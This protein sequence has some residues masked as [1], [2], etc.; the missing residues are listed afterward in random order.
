MKSGLTSEEAVIKLK[1]SKPPP[2]GIE[3]Y[4]YLQQIWKQEQMSS[5]KD[6]LRWYNNEDV[7]PILDAM[8]KMIAFYHDKDIDM[9]KLGCTL[10]NLANI[11]LHKSTDAKFYQFTESDKD[12]IK[13]FEK[14]LLVVHPSILHANQLLMKL[15][16]E[17]LQTCANLLLG[18]MPANYILT[19][20]VNPCRP[21]SIRVGISI[22]KLV[23]S[24]LDKTRPAVLEIWSCLISN[25]QYQKVKLRAALQ[26]ADKKMTPSVLMG[27]VLNATLCS[28]PWVAFTT[29]ASAKSCVPLSLKRI[30]NVVASKKREL[31]AMRRHYI[32]EKGCKVIEM[33]EC[34]F[35]RLYKTTKTVK[36]HIR[37][38]FPYRRSLA[39]EQVLEDIKKG[40]LFGYVQCDIE[41]PEFSRP[42]FDNF[43]PI[44]EN[45]LVSKNDIGDLMKTYAEEE[46]IMSQPR[47]MLISSFTLQNGALITP[48]LLF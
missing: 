21:D 5:F 23:D 24:H 30:I 1:L 10:P 2:T 31:D 3:K 47:K 22:Q 48:L 43:P 38:H 12:L 34:E 15:L 13:N 4:Q 19:Q 11:C 26:Q 37:E 8:Q 41:V 28:K 20:C 29:S 18:L 14:M 25:E 33:W 40:K 7:V 9:L 39:A 46:G 45:T 35:W 27:F 44:F 17:S 16:S 36:Q 6:F 42:K 32:Q